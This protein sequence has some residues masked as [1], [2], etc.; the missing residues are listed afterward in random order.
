VSTSTRLVSRSL[1][2][3]YDS[4]PSSASSSSNLAYPSAERWTSTRLDK[5]PADDAADRLRTPKEALS[6]V[7][8]ACDFCRSRQ[9][10]CDGAQPTCSSCE[11]RQ[12]PCSLRYLAV[13]PCDACRGS[14]IGCDCVHPTC[15]PC[16]Q[17]NLSCH[18]VNDRNADTPDEFTVLF[19][20]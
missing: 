6:H 8:V 13:I 4:A 1:L 20:P 18:Y 16:A 15:S 12:L 17:K 2:S 11:N 5:S 19:R 7:L 14:G 9:M 10:Q 3:W